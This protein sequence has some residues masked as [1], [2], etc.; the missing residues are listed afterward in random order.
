MGGIIGVGMMEGKSG[1]NWRF[2][3]A[4][5]KEAGRVYWSVGRAQA[6]THMHVHIP[7]E[8]LTTSTTHPKHRKTGATF[9]SWAMTLVVMGGGTA[10]LF[11]QGVYAPCVDVRA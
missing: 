8:S 3:G 10:L 7:N 2:L 4:Y 9:A 11:A 1:V 6:S 5:A